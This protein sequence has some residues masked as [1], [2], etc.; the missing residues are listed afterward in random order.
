MEFQQM[1]LKFL[2]KQTTHHPSVPGQGGLCVPTW[3]LEVQDQCWPAGSLVLTSRTTNVRDGSGLLLPALCPLPWH[4]PSPRSEA[5][6]GWAVGGWLVPTV[7]WPVSPSSLLVLCPDGFWKCSW[8]LVL[9]LCQKPLLSLR[10]L[11]H[12]VV[13][14]SHGS[15]GRWGGVRASRGVSGGN[16]GQLL[17][18]EWKGWWFSHTSCPIPPL[19]PSAAR[20]RFVCPPVPSDVKTTRV[21]FLMLGDGKGCEGVTVLAKRGLLESWRSRTMAG[22]EEHWKYSSSHLGERRY[23]VGHSTMLE[24]S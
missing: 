7:V 21:V 14:L 22:V 6:A 8:Y 3:P 11:G 12:S 16:V 5:G 15:R 17:T 1:W 10:Q 19:P 4:P 2:G 23:S 24:I 13:L 18:Q 9:S 20:I